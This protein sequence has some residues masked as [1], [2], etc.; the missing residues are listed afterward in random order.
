MPPVSLGTITN[1]TPPI[2]PSPAA[3]ALRIV[4]STAKETGY[5]SKL[6]RFS[7][8]VGFVALRELYPAGR[9]RGRAR[10]NWRFEHLY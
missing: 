9:G 2:S 4:N 6:R 1:N 3:L 7:V 8:A 10:G 5:E